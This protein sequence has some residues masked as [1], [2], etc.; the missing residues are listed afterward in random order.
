M[1]KELKKSDIAKKLVAE[2]VVYKKGKGNS[3]KSLFI[4]PLSDFTK[5][6]RLLI[7][8]GGFIVMWDGRTMGCDFIDYAP[9]DLGYLLKVLTKHLEKRK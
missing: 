7:N 6:P 9:K 1:K 5:S 2:Y 8:E 4:A 3:I